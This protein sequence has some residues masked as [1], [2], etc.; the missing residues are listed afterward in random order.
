MLRANQ[1]ARLPVGARV[2]AD[3][4]GVGGDRPAVARAPDLLRH[5]LASD[6]ACAAQTLE[7]D[8]HAAGMKPQLRCELVGPR[9]VAEA[10]QVSEQSRARRLG[11]HVTRTVG[12]TR[13]HAREFL[14]E[15]L[16]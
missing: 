8:A 6:Q 10:R 12:P 9:R 13:S 14:I 3:R 4:K 16:V 11:Q 5:A 2:L 1:R 7:M 15:E